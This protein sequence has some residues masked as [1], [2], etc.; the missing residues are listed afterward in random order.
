MSDKNYN[1][2]VVWGVALVLM[3][4]MVFF[5]I[6]RIMPKIEQIESFS[7][8]IGFIRFCL[9]FMAVMLTAGGGKKLYLHFTSHNQDAEPAD[10]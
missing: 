6:P 10:E 7:S 1:I 9:Y 4:I 3:G 5:R 8:S 2:Q